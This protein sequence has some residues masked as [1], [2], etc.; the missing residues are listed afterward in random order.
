MGGTV[1]V[2]WGYGPLV[3]ALQLSR[4]LGSP[5]YWRIGG[6]GGGSIQLLPAL[7]PCLYDG[8]RVS[9][10]KSPVQYYKSW[11]PDYITRIR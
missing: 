11:T 4:V 7:V 1:D 10:M 2:F 9:G 8:N 5:R 6:G 3:D